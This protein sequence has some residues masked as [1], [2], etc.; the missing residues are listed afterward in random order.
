MVSPNVLEPSLL[1]EPYEGLLD[2]WLKTMVSAPKPIQCCH[3]GVNNTFTYGG[4]VR[5]AKQ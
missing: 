1:N 4:F 2:V 3:G 5:Y